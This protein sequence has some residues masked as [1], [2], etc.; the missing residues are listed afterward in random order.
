MIIWKVLDSEKKVRSVNL[1]TT[2]K[3]MFLRFCYEWDYVLDVKI[4]SSQRF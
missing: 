1:L 3:R 2:A 4:R